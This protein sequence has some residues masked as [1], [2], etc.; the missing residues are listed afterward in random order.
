[1]HGDDPDSGERACISKRRLQPILIDCINSPTCTW[2]PCF[3]CF[4]WPQP[5]FATVQ[6]FEDAFSSSQRGIIFVVYHQLQSLSLAPLCFAFGLL[7]LGA[8]QL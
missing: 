7:K 4:P 1:M 2:F 5:A 8:M 6:A 3:T